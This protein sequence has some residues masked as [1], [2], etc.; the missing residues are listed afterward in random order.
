MS[1]KSRYIVLLILFTSLSINSFSQ[2]KQYFVVISTDYGKMKVQLYN[3][4]PKH[5]DSF[6]KLVN[7]GHFDGTLFYR[8]IKDFV[9]QGGSSD[10]K[11]APKGK[12]IGYGSSKLT[13]DSEFQT[14]NIHK[15]GA[16]CAP[17]QPD[18]INVF[19]MSDIS[20]FYIVKGRKYTNEEL[21]LL[22]KA[23]NNPIKI[24]LKKKYYLPFK[25]E[26]QKLKK[27]NPKAFNTKLREI[28]Q[29]IALQYEVSNKLEFTPKQREAYTTVGGL[30]DLDGSYTVFGEVV[31]GLSIIDKIAATATDKNDRPYKDVKIVAEIISE[32]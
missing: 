15:K 23:R 5:R 18:Q 14:G 8:V 25:E 20:Q 27:E 24:A 10:S 1:L 31:E 29:N 11:N 26:L 22:E 13:I 19:Q 4:T 28:K 3:N 30:P 16:I 9:I 12:H 21:D 2:E 7:Q 17:R 6:I 32:N